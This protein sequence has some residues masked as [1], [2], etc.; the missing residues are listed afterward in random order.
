VSRA[1]P[2]R[3]ASKTRKRSRRLRPAR[4]FTLS[5]EAIAGLEARSAEACEPG[6]R[7]VDR[8]ILQAIREKDWGT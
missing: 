8:L 3:T 2:I 1:A 6:S 7:I 4:E 5:P